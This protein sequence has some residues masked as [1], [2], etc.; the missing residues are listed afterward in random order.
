I[1]NSYGGVTTVNGG[2]LSVNGEAKL[3][4]APGSPTPGQLVLNGG[5]LQAT[6]GFTLNSNRGIAQGPASGSGSGTIDVT[7]SNT[8]SYAGIVANNGAGTGALVKITGG[9]LVLAS[10]NT[11]SGGTPINGGVLQFGYGGTSGSL[12]SGAVTDTTCLVFNRTDS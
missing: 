12:G 1:S 11:Y 8:L 4:T 7:G 10:A 5:T 6:D 3:G 2:T 9:T